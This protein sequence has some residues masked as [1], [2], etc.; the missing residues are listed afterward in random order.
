MV[1]K[2]KENSL[3]FI[4]DPRAVKLLICLRIQFSNLNEQKFRH[5]FS[6]TYLHVELK[7]NLLNIS[8]CIV[9]F[10]GLKD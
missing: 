2:K 9:N 7:L 3:F 8:S 10:T 5:G 1:K 4:Y 6:N